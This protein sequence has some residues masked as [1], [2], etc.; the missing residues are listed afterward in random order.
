VRFIFDELL[1]DDAT[2]DANGFNA[3]TLAGRLV[4]ARTVAEIHE[5]TVLVVFDANV[6]EA[7]DGFVVREG[8]VH[9]F[10]D[11]SGSI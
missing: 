3:V 4:P 2:V 9:H 11:S 1:D 8:V 6:V 10:A 7:R 5:H